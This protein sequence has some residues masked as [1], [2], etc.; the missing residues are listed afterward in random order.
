[1]IL[2]SLGIKI[3]IIVFASLIGLYLIFCLVVGLIMFNLML[4]R[5]KNSY[6]E[7]K[8]LLDFKIVGME[9]SELFPDVKLLVQAQIDFSEYLK[10]KEITYLEEKS[11][12]GI[13]LAGWYIKNKD[14]DNNNHPKIMIFCH[15]WKSSGITDCATSAPFYLQS[16]YDVVIV[17]HQAHSH[18]EGHYLGFGIL[19]SKSML[20][21]V[22]KID[23]MHQGNCDIYLHGVS[24]GANT[25]MLLNGMDLPA[26]VK[27][28]CADCG[29]TSG[30]E[31]ISYLAKNRKLT[32]LL[33]KQIIWLLALVICRYNIK[34]S[35]ID[36][37]KK[38]H[39]PM[40]FIHGDKDN[41]VPMEHS[42][43]NYDACVSKKELK[44]FSGGT[45]AS[46][47]VKFKEE[48]KNTVLNFFNSLE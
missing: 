40:L 28:M 13:R 24:M 26:S 2:T 10:D 32:V 41:F 48:Y 46:C 47:Y 45:H 18:S 22:N 7:S 16:G 3:T 23:L 4:V 5:E 8:D 1:M 43:A 14:N 29:F 19:D 9:N 30:Y 35:S 11:D 39:V 42:L 15:G 33:T 21:W 31:E 38:A 20:K 36:A 25:L 27:G 12:R 37:L 17:D 34:T 44:I 6:K